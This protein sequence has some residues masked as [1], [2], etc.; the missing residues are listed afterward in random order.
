MYMTMLSNFKSSFRS[1][2]EHVAVIVLAIVPAGIWKEQ[3]L[4]RF[5]R[6]RYKNLLHKFPVSRSFICDDGNV[7]SVL[8]QRLYPKTALSSTL[9][10]IQENSGN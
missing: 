10:D 6:K 9:L 2:T 4:E 5:W 7:H 1:C 3:L 8:N